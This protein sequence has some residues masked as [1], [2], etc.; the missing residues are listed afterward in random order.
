MALFDNGNPEEFLLF[1]WNFQ[2]TLEESGYIAAS[3]NIRSLPTM[4]RGEVLHQLDVLLCWDG[5]YNHNTFKPHYFGFMYI[6][7][8]C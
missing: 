2:M 8:S 7:I 1:V 5:N 4:L 3:I 6:I